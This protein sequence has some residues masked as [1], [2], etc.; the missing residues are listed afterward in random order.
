MPRFESYDA[1]YAAIWNR[2]GWD[3]GFISNPF[4]GD[5]AARLGL[6]RTRLVLERLGDPDRKLPLV[7]VAGS[8]GKGST[9]AMLHAIYRASG[10]KSGR[11][12]SPHLH[13]IRE[14]FVGDEAMIGHKDF[15]SI[16]SDVF[17]AVE[18]VETDYPD[19]GRLTA[20]EISVTMALLWFTRCQCDIAVMEV[21]MGGTLD[22]TNVI[23]PVV[24][25]ITRL[26][27]EHTAILGKTMP[28]IAANKAGIIKQGIPVVTVNQ[29]PDGLAVIEHRARALDAPLLVAGRDWTVEG[30]DREFQVDGPW[31]T[32]NGLA[33]AL[34]GKH[35]LENAG[36]AIAA[37]EAVRRHQTTAPFATEVGIR[38][39][40]RTATLPGRFEVV[41]Q[42][43][44]Q[45]V[46][47]DGAHTPASM[48]AL[49]LTVRDRFGDR[50]I[51]VIAGMLAGR[52]PAEVLAPLASIATSIVVTTSGNPRSIPAT[53][54]AAALRIATAPV[55]AK[56]TVGEALADASGRGA[57]LVVVTGSFGVVADAR[58]CLGLNLSPGDPVAQE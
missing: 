10:L 34:P 42:G 7:H 37:T 51:H 26:D 39:G 5:D 33:L 55:S 12:T 25:V 18:T 58:T 22:A 46:V 24:S 45:V 52:D 19:A 32:Y 50:P 29:P 15:A 43:R 16:A 6:V 14:R 30:N 41:D 3:R 47:L 23:S 56:S 1:A 2:S 11:F 53:D 44:G 13:T 48:D 38:E 20:W 17:D 8:K 4:A 9:T 36:L 31:W 40:L 54:L 28:E 57:P 21:G 35:Q 49:T 27:F